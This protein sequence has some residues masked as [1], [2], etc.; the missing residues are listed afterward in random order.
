VLLAFLFAES[1]YRERPQAAI[2]F[3]GHHEWTPEEQHVGIFDRFFGPPSRDKFARML[4]QAIEKA[5][6]KEPILYDPERFCLHSKG[7]GVNTLNLTNAYN[8]YCGA[9]KEQ[10]PSVVHNFV[11]T[12]F[13]HRKEMPDDFES[14]RHDLLLG[15][16][17]RMVF[18]HT[19][20]KMKMDGHAEFNWPYRA[21]AESL[22]IGL[23]YDLPS[24]MVQVQQHLLDQWKA[25]FEEAYEVAC[26]NLRGITKHTL[27]EVAPGVQASPW[28]DNYDPSRMLLVDY[29]RHHEV[30]GDPVVM[31]P[32]RDTLLL[33]GSEDSAGLGKL[34]EIAEAAHEHPRPLSLIACRLTDED[35]WVPFLPPPEHPQY[36]QYRLFQIRCFGS[37][38]EEQKATLN[39]FHEKTGKDIF[40]ASF[41]AVEKQD[42]GEIRSYCV[43]SQGV[44]AFLPKADYVYFFQP[45]DDEKGDIVAT[46]PWTIAEAVLGDRLTPVGLYPERYLVEGFPTEEEIAAFGFH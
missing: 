11:Q 1:M 7:E 46:V 23:I 13:A 30:V 35:E 38:Y 26:E 16:R 22:G 20:M 21:L 25:T 19:A 14:A 17:T 32:N 45:G 8:E 10:K 3:S 31:V 44:S 9:S 5:G 24:S 33:T 36:K 41:S 34:A 37:D 2:M 28:Q 27:N 42:T 4:Q 6:E 18:E 29:I 39:E 43:W 40:V 15:I 12:W